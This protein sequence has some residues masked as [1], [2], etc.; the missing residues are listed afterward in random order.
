MPAPDDPA[1]PGLTPDDCFVYD[2]ECEFG[3]QPV[4]RPRATAMQLFAEEMGVGWKD[5]SCRVAYM[6]IYTRQESFENGSAQYQAVDDWIDSH[7][8]PLKLDRECNWV[9]PDGT[10]VLLPADLEIVPDDWEPDEEDPV[11]EFCAQ[12]NPQAVKVWRLDFR[13]ALR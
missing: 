8:P 9:T 6:R 2:R 12:N 10:V 7:D 5:V 13:R 3:I 11:W 4:T 1:F